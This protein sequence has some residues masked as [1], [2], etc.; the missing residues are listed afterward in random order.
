MGVFLLVTVRLEA[1]LPWQCGL[2][3]EK[4]PEM[5]FFQ[6][7]RRSSPASKEAIALCGEPMGTSARSKV[8]KQ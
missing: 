7:K 2:A 5:V 4:I 3:H 1:I 8:A 6:R